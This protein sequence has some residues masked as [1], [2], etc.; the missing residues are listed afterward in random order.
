MAELNKI[1]DM[2]WDK[3]MVCPID[4]EALEACEACQ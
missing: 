2:D 4:P 1:T 3:P